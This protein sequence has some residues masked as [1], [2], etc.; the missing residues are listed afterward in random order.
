MNDVLMA[1]PFGSGYSLQSPDEK[2]GGFSLLSLTR[3]GSGEFYGFFII[4]EN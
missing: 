2:S 3:K 1:L 4:I